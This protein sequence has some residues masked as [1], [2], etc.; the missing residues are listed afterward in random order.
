MKNRLTEVLG[1]QGLQI[2]TSVEDAEND[3]LAKTLVFARGDGP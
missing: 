1:I 3:G 2:F